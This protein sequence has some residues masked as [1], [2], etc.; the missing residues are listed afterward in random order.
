VLG[1]CDTHAGH[2]TAQCCQQQRKAPR[3]R[4]NSQRNIRCKLE[5]G[6]YIKTEVAT[7]RQQTVEEEDREP[8]PGSLRFECYH[9][10]P[11]ICPRKDCSSA[12]T[13]SKP[14]PTMMATPELLPTTQV[15]YK[16]KQ[17]TVTLD[18]SDLVVK[19]QKD[20]GTCKTTTPQ[21]IYGE[22]YTITLPSTGFVGDQSNH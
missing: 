16:K 18:A 15:T 8:E 22:H 13:F 3:A 12:C 6:S 5:G 21:H 20:V 19:V 17:A 10:N 9:G 14:H 11:A 1:I 7:E 2:R 4:N